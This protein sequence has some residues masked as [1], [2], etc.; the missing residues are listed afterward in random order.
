MARHKQAAAPEQ[1]PQQQL[2]SPRGPLPLDDGLHVQHPPP[3][4]LVAGRADRPLSVHTRLFWMIQTPDVCG[5]C[6]SC[7]QRWFSRPQALLRF[8]PRALALSRLLQH[9]DGI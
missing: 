6:R 5:C 7:H 3:P 2:A 8:V 1:L 4:Q 9:V